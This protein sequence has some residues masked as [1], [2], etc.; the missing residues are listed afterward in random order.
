MLSLP[1]ML[2]MFVLINPLASFPMLIAAFRKRMDAK[3][4]AVISVAVAFAIAM[5]MVFIGPLLFTMFG[6][7]ID[8][9]MI[10]GGLILLL[11]GIDTVRHPA[12][13][14]EASPDEMD[15]FISLIATPLLTGPATMSFIILKT[16]EMNQ[17]DLAVNVTLTFVAIGVLFTLLA[18]A[19][20]KVNAKLVSIISKIMGLFLTAMGM[21]MM[22]RGIQA[23]M[24]VG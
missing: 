16:Y 4:I 20:P 23:M 8:S 1:L 11:L 13:Y 15:G 14:G 19:V 3:K 5:L 6:I 18:L 10:A 9:F 17:T 7:G 12:E 2:Q 21:E 22:V 24:L